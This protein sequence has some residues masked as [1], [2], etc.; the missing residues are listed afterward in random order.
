MEKPGPGHSLVINKGELKT[1]D[2]G[3]RK[4][5]RDMKGNTQMAVTGTRKRVLALA[6]A[7]ALSLATIMPTFAAGTVTQV[8]NCGASNS[9]AAS[10]A[11]MSLTAVTFSTV[12]QDSQGNL[13]LAATENGC[14]AKGW[15]VTIQASEWAKDGGG[16]AI[17]D[18]AFALMQVANPTVVS[19]QGIDNNGGPKP[20]NS[21]GVLN[22]SR[23]V[24]HANQGYGLGSYAQNLGVKLTIPAVTLPGTY[25]TTVTTTITTGP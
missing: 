1:T 15:N 8:I 9:L 11:D 20:V 7:V 6:G 3:E 12:A 19:G 2:L 24:L 4:M 17:P 14:A 10:I 23:K 25:K 21:I 16:T 22:Q 13:T 5:A 18:T